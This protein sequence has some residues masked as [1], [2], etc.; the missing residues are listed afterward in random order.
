MA[1]L[2]L[3]TTGE[4][5]PSASLCPLTVLQDFQWGLL[6]Q[7]TLRCLHV[8]LGAHNKYLQGHMAEYFRCLEQSMHIESNLSVSK[9]AVSV[10]GPRKAQPSA[11]QAQVIPSR[12]AEGSSMEVSHSASQGLGQ[13]RSL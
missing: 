4:T 6:P 3:D 5:V 11:A 13:G 7:D 8:T 10:Q 2:P 1:F 12:K 9:A